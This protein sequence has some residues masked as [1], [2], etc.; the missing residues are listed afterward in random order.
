MFDRVVVPQR[1][2]LIYRS[3]QTLGY[4]PGVNVWERLE[5]DT[6]EVLRWLRAGRPKADAGAHLQ[7]RFGYT[8]E[9]AQERLEEIARWGLFR[10]MFYLDREPDVPLPVVP[11][12][13]LK[14]VY[15]ICTQA[16][17]LRCTYCYQDATVARPHELTTAEAK[18]LVDQVVEAG[19]QTF[20]ITG[21]EPFSRRDLMEIVQYAKGR[22]LR[23]NVITNGHYITEKN[24]KEVA[25]AFNTITISLDHGLA[26]HHDC[27]RGEGSWERAVRAVD[28]LLAEGA[29]VDLNSVLSHEGLQDIKELIRFGRKR[30]IGTHKIMPQYPMGRGAENRYG[31]LTVPELLGLNDRLNQVNIDLESEGEGELRAPNEAKGTS[32]GT[33]RAHCGAGLAE[34]SVDPEGWVYPCKLLQYTEL[35]SDNIRDRRLAEIVTHPVI[36][37]TAK[38]VVDTLHPCKTCIVKNHCGGGCRGIHYSFTGA[39]TETEPLFCAHLRRSFEVYAWSTTGEVPPERTTGFKFDP[40]SPAVPNFI[41]LSRLEESL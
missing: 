13:P 40:A 32:K 8:P 21:G 41:P 29:K 27:N 25:K 31:E 10:R 38:R 2:A 14:M 28:L 6:A 37:G 26:K 24:A 39:Y 11:S 20:I 23:V 15:W 34:V 22:G 36:A 1:L 7:R 30:K 35:R 18:D 17:N 5:P 3:G 4:N 19:A 16:C 33:R 12:R 9:R